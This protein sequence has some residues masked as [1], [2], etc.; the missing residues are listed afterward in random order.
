MS[1]KPLLLLL[2]IALVALPTVAGA[3]TDVCLPN[4]IGVP[5]LGGPPNWWSA[6]LPGWEPLDDPRWRGAYLETFG[7]G[8]ASEH[9]SFRGLRTATDLY[10]SW[11]V[12]VDPTLDTQ[13][14]LWVGFAPGGGEDELLLNIQPFSTSNTAAEADPVVNISASVRPST[15]GAWSP[16]PGANV[17][18]W[19]EAATTRTAAWR[20]VSGSTWAV[21]MRVPLQAGFENGLDLQDEFRLWYE[22]QVFHD[23]GC[24]PPGTICNVV[25]YNFPDNL[26]FADVT[27][28]ASTSGSWG[29]LRRDVPPTNAACIQGVSLV[30][31]DIGTETGGGPCSNAASNLSG[32]FDL[33]DGA[34]SPENNVVCARPQND[35]G[36]QIGAGDLDAVFRIANWGT[37]PD[38]NDVADPT[39][40][41]RQIN[42]VPAT[43]TAPVADGSKGSITFD[44]QLTPQEACDFDPQPADIDCTGFP[45]PT[46]RR[47]QCMLV[48]LSGA[49]GLTF[50][51]SSVVRNMNFAEASVFKREAQ[52]SVVGLK[53]L[54][55]RSEREVYLYVQTLNM[56][57]QVEPQDPKPSPNRPERSHHRCPEIE[58]S[59]CIEPLEPGAYEELRDR[60]PTYQVHAYHDTGRELKSGGRV[61]RVLRPQTS[62][63]YFMHHEGP[64][65]GWGHELDGAKQIGPDYYRIEV[66]N[67]GARTITNVIEA[68]EDERPRPRGGTDAEGRLSGSVHAGINRPSSFRGLELEGGSSFGLDLS[69]R[70]ASQFEI[71]LFLGRDRIADEDLDHLALNGR[72]LLGPGPET[73]FLSAGFGRYEVD[74][75]GDE[76][77][78]LGAGARFPLTPKLDF[79][80]SAKLHR[81]SVEDDDLDFITLQ[82]GLR[83]DLF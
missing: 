14:Q 35:T 7:G 63:G 10:L 34:G 59:R 67:D 61:W 6:T 52:V 4:A 58:R 19:L 56:P 12:E 40:L 18:D 43:T 66:P 26:T 50:S 62:F 30:S 49:P 42:A 33:S 77:F 16:A 55:G 70:V 5:A 23:I 83:F 80:T 65:T 15:G 27:D 17:P 1:R 13:D 8:A 78:H 47:H 76:G 20:E 68:F 64:L 2:L 48:E 38:W 32:T 46:R 60:E 75:E 29:D 44:W 51:S 21:Q 79:E 45:A 37:Q 72:Y 11:R 39:T 54:P 81:V 3:Q 53:G 57:R 36:G 69:Y 9:V 24:N 82:A 71:E 28:P 31:S 22:V 41:W 73:F 74:G 25:E